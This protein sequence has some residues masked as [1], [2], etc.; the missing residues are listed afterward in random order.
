[1]SAVLLRYPCLWELDLET[2]VGYLRKGHPG[3]PLL[4]LQ[5]DDAA[6][7]GDDPSRPVAPAV[8]QLVARQP[9]EPADEAPVVA[10]GTEGPVEAGRGD[11]ERVVALDR[12]L[13]VEDGGDLLRDRL[14]V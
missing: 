12:V 8:H 7:A 3:L 6:L 2:A 1:M 4:E 9:C 11:L 5:G 13:R 10:L 14:E